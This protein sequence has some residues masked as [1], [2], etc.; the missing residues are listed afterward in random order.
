[1]RFSPRRRQVSVLAAAA[2]IVLIFSGIAG[3]RGRHAAPSAAPSPRQQQFARAAT[4]FGVPEPLLLA[5]S[6]TLSRW[7]DARGAPVDTASGF[8]PMHL[9]AADGH[10][11][12]QTV[13][14][15]GANLAA[16]VRGVDTDPALHTLEAAAALVHQPPGLISR[17]ATLN[18]RAGAALLAH[19]AGTPRPAGVDG[20]YDAV[21]RYA[22]GGTVTPAARQLADA[23][24]DVLRSGASAVTADGQRMVLAAQA[25]HAGAAGRAG[26]AVQCPDGLSCRFVQAAGYERAQRAPGQ[27]QFLV[28]GS[29][30]STYEQGVARMADARA[31]TSAHYL[32]RGSDGQVTQLVRTGDVALFAGSAAL[33]DLSVGIALDSVGS[34]GLPHYSEATYASAAALVR[35]LA[36]AYRIPLDRQ[37]VLGRDELPTRAATRPANDPGARW[38]WGHLFALIGKPMN[39]P[40]D[41][42]GRA[43]AF[44]PAPATN[45]QP[46]QQ[47][48]VIG[49][50]CA[51]L[52][53]QQVNFV[54]LRVAPSDTAP[55]LSDPL[56]HPDGGPGSTDLADF[57]DKAVAGQVFAVAE[58]RTGWTAIWYGG[59]RAWFRDVPGLTRQVRSPLVT[60]AA[61]LGSA[62]VYSDPSG[63][64]DVAYVLAAGQSY[65]LLGHLP[66]GFEII[67]FNHGIAFVRTAEVTLSPA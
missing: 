33:N 61:G 14:P 16:V 6:Y 55:L 35:Y 34:G 43:V 19:Y 28:L 59:Q 20:W 23:V 51:D 41:D 1:V 47:C 56:A 32:I 66:G 8:G 42:F 30:G 11:Y 48:A 64:P 36:A 26:Q 38:D 37:H 18:I 12:A 31:F 15:Q 52:G 58:R 10:A 40:T 27:V 24:Y 13:A 17:D 22:G 25:V 60:P 45:T 7:E 46:V 49:L 54:P 4:E 65:P 62:D 44:V 39:G 2:L 67:G 63:T 5:L 29:A 53:R 57:G 9:T 21:A 3:A 50:G